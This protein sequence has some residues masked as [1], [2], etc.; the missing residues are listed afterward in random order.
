M[1]QTL[2]IPA[3]AARVLIVDDEVL[4]VQ[5]LEVMLG[6]Q[7]FVLLTAASGEEALALTA[8]ERPDIILLD[9]MMPGM[10]GYEVVGRLKANPAT[11]SIPII[12]VS[13]L[14]G[15]K[16]RLLGLSAGAEDFISKPVDRAELQARVRNLL[17]LKAYGDYHRKHG[18]LL[19]A[20]VISRTAELVESEKRYRQIVESTSDGIVKVDVAG[21]IVF[22]NRRFADMLGY[23]VSELGGKSALSFMSRESQTIA[24]EALTSR[25]QGEAHTHDIAFRRKDGGVLAVSL[26]T[27]PIVDEQGRY[28][29]VLGSARDMSEQRELLARLTL[30]DRM[31]SIGTLAAGVAHEINNPLACVMANLD[32][33]TDSLLGRAKKLGVAADFTEVYEEIRDAREASER[34]RNIV[35]DLRM[36]SRSEEEK[37]GPVDVGRVLE[38]TLRMARNEIR[39]RARVVKNYG[40]TPPVEASEAR[41]GRCS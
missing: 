14:D 37:R 21:S 35:R 39:H 24:I 7:G 6:Q 34:I 2:D 33:A 1:S 29:G 5:L 41:L 27:T 15:R 26:A 10:D 30:S 19:E 8:R 28:V 18:Q 31:A 12:M 25:S 9:A 23:S 38:S 11:E 22:A 40:N 13:A 4:N 32:L 3:A 17:R 16:A 36:F 20:E